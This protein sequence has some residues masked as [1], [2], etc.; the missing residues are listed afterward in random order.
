MTVF[1]KESESTMWD[2]IKGLCGAWIIEA[3]DIAKEIVP[4][5]L[6]ACGIH[7]KE[8]RYNGYWGESTFY[9]D[10]EGWNHEILITACDQPHGTFGCPESFNIDES[11]NPALYWYGGENHPSEYANEIINTLLSIKEEQEQILA[12]ITNID[13]IIEQNKDLLAGQE[14][15]MNVYG[16]YHKTNGY[17]YDVDTEIA[18]TKVQ[19]LR[20]SHNQN[21]VF[22]VTEDNVV[23]H[24][25][26]LEEQA[27]KILGE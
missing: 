12:S 10:I 25:T 20:I 19:F 11:L 6:P 1:V 8:I 16:E 15:V 23:N 18:Q 17:P 27:F 4:Q 14:V 2:E 21:P 13:V 5:M 24:I 3:K 26:T 22:I 7:I 9:L